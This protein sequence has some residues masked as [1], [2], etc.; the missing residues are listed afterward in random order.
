MFAGLAVAHLHTGSHGELLLA[1]PRISGTSLPTRLV[2]D[3]GSRGMIFTYENRH[4]AAV[5]ALNITR[6]VTL[7]GTNHSFPFVMEHNIAHGRFFRE[8][9]VRYRHR[10]AVLNMQAS[11]A[12]FGTMEATGNEIIINNL[13]YIVAGVIDDGEPDEV[14]IYVPSS[15]RGETTEALTANLTLSPTLT[16]IGV[17]NEWQRMGIDSRQYLF[18]NFRVMQTVVRDKVI[19][20]IA[21]IVVAAMAFILSKA[22]FSAKNQ[23]WALRRLMHEAYIWG[24]L[25]KPPIWKL[26][27]IVVAAAGIASAIA[28][29]VIDAFMRGLAAYDVRGMLANVQSEAFSRQIAEMT[30]WYNLSN[31]FFLGFVVFFILLIL[32]NSAMAG[33]T[34]SHGRAVPR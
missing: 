28:A 6:S 31:L 27:G 2:E 16:D 21:M 12:L 22:Y 19:L 15:L 29:I 32:L 17:M 1:V 30:R 11:F 14:I 34:R 33:L 24:V 5:T 13:P 3:A 4:A 23:G 18:V 9:A 8:Y 20:A 10:V 25:A 26:M 7:I